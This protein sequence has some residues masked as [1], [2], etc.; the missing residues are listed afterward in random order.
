MTMIEHSIAFVYSI[1]SKVYILILFIT[2][3]F[4]IGV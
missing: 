3:L 1:G 4:S 2:Q